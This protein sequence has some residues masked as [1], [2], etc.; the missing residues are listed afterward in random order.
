M[1]QKHG[2]ISRYFTSI[3]KN[4]KEKYNK[5]TRITAFLYIN[6]YLLAIR[7]KSGEGI[8][9]DDRIQ[10]DP[11]KFQSIKLINSIREFFLLFFNP[12]DIHHMT[13]YD[14]IPWKLKKTKV[15]VSVYD[16]IHELFPDQFPDKVRLVKKKCIEGADLIICISEYTKS[17][18][19]RLLGIDEKK[20]QVIYIGF[21]GFDLNNSISV[22]NLVGL[23]NPYI[24]FV[25][26]RSGYK[27][28]DNLVKAFSSSEQLLQD[29]NLV[30]VGGGKFTKHETDMFNEFN[31]SYKLYQI[32]ANDD[33]LQRCYQNASI[34]IYPSLYEGFGIPPLEAMSCQ[35]PVCCSSTSSLPEVVGDAAILF[36][37]EDIN[38]IKDAM[39]LVL[40]NPKVREDLVFKG[41]NRIK[42]FTWEKCAE[43]TFNAYK[44]I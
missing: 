1:Y 18:L 10:S 14:H 16:M 26:Q 6:S 33:M 22:N 5:Y 36:N 24:L 2:G 21:K 11:I 19:I 8:Y 38:S 17:D 32:D 3:Y 40:Y 30:C 28:F 37:P 29:Y 27:N 12:P 35:T 13:Y 7:A 39:I 43:E 25:G 31:I 23:S 42:Y 34:F 15:V 4:I 20:I 44:T 9:L 41:E